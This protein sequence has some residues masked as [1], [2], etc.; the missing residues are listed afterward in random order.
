MLNKPPPSPSKRD[1]DNEPLMLTEP[2][3]IEP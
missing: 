3:N 1:A 2:V